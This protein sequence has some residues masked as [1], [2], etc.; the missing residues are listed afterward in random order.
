MISTPFSGRNE[1]WPSDADLGVA[2]SPRKSSK[3][4]G[5]AEPS[6]SFVA[7]IISSLAG[8]L[9]S[10]LLSI[11]ITLLIVLNFA[12]ARGVERAGIDL[13]MRLFAVFQYQLDPT[14]DAPPYRYAFI[15]LGDVPCVVPPQATEWPCPEGDPVSPALVRAWISLARRLGAAVIIVDL[16][17]PTSPADRAALVEAGSN[18]GPALVIA[19]LIADPKGGGPNLMDP[20]DPLIPAPF[21]RGSL[22]LAPLITQTDPIAGD[23]IVRHYPPF[24]GVGAGHLPTAPFLAAAWMA[25]GAPARNFGCDYYERRAAE[26]GSVRHAGARAGMVASA[27][28][29]PGE[30]SRVFWSIR[31]Q[32]DLSTDQ[33]ALYDS[34]VQ[35][36][37]G[38]WVRGHEWDAAAMRDR[39]VVI[40]SGSASAR[41]LHPTPLGV[42]PGPEVVLN[43][44]RSFLEFASLR[45]STGPTSGRDIATTILDKA[46]A[47]LL[48]ALLLLPAWWAIHRARLRAPARRWFHRLFVG[49]GVTFFFLFS[50]AAG[51][52][53]ELYFDAAAIKESAL[54]GQPIDL[55]A[56]I[57]ALGLEAFADAAKRLLTFLEDIILRAAE[58]ARLGWFQFFRFVTSFRG[59]GS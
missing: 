5:R 13:G 56:P 18:A 42:T 33:R 54:Q 35:Y 19:P 40:G 9:F 44:T 7:A 2:L 6:G 3:R 32:G 34:L 11:V 41:D 57:L 20:T 31:P 45:E 28:P 37:P 24:V 43:A 52:A 29:G 1:D 50:L 48:P 49:A 58:L 21:A 22:R 16:E 47:V 26:C 27:A 46:K 4:V 23:G 36:Y 59:E 17:T 10:V 25:G 30:L 51:L 38:S 12:P 55:V 15:D 39:I 8:Y 53:S 14:F